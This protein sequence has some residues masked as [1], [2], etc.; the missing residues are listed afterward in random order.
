MLSVWG[1]I[2]GQV[3]GIGLAQALHPTLPLCDRV[4]VDFFR[5]YGKKEDRLESIEHHI[6]IWTISNFYFNINL[7]S[8]TCISPFLSGRWDSDGMKMRWKKGR[9]MEM[10]EDEMVHGMENGVNGG[11]ESGMKSGE[12]DGM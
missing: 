10:M 2:P 3:I 6:W 7:P 4:I 5:V 12:K 1:S 8:L 11:M 9:K